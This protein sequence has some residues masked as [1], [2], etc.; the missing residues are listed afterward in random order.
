M[1]DLNQLEQR[2]DVVFR[3]KSLLQRALIHRSYLNEHPEFPLEDNERLDI[4]QAQ[5]VAFRAWMRDR[6][7]SPMRPARNTSSR[8]PASSSC[9]V[10]VTG[11]DCGPR[12]DF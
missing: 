7:S 6:E 10:I 5:L 9:T 11:R 12:L 4:F 3:D 1:T 8:A 2:L